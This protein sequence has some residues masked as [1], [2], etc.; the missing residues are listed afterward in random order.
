M[1]RRALA[2]EMRTKALL[3][4]RPSRLRRNST[5]EFSAGFSANPSGSGAARSDGGFLVEELH[6]NAQHLCQIEQPAGAD[7]VDALLVFLHLLERQAE[8]LAELLLAHAEQHAPKANAAADVHIDRVRPS[9][10][11]LV[12]LALRRRN[13]VFST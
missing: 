12:A 1:A 11:L 5:M 4:S 9:R 13:R 6:R 2:S 7:A 8:L 3:S 10:A